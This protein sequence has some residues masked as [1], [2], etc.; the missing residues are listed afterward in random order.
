MEMPAGG[1]SLVTGSNQNS[2]PDFRQILPETLE[3]AKG[4]DDA[5]QKNG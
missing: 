2:H 1:A 3:I 4:L 5:G